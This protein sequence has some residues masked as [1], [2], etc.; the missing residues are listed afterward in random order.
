MKGNMTSQNAMI[1]FLVLFHLPIYYFLITWGMNLALIV[2]WV[3]PVIGATI[4]GSGLL[5]PREKVKA[6][7]EAVYTMDDTALNKVLNKEANAN[8][9]LT[10]L[11]YALAVGGMM[12]MATTSNVVV[13]MGLAYLVFRS[14]WVAYVKRIIPIAKEVI[15]EQ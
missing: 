1:F 10:Q 3:F 7:L 4:M 2:V 9:T 13:G 12:I 6:S 8:W 15:Q 5:I 14:M 11:G